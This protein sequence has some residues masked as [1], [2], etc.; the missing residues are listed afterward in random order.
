[1]WKLES[2]IPKDYRVYRNAV[3]NSIC[4]Q[5]FKYEDQE[6]NSWYS[7]TDLAQL[8]YTRQFAAQKVTSLYTLGLSKEDLKRHTDGL[9][10]L[11]KSND[12]EKYEKAYAL[13]LD[14]ENKAANATDAVKQLSALVC[15]YFTL[16]D[17]P[18]DSFED[19]L[20]IKKM[21]LLEANPEM[22]NFFLQ[23][24]IR[25]TETYTNSL[26]ALLQTVSIVQ[27]DYSAL[28]KGSY[29]E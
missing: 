16:N 19:S 2:E 6:K 25:L 26:N 3:T 23:E 12:S 22:H 18:I 21:A 8:P 7:F 27:R 20:Q 28:M 11:L 4:K 17:E 29:S 9:K 5:E 15:V 14:F 10:S 13:V 24:Q 1:M